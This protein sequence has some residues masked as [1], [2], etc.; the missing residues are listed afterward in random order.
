MIKRISSRRL[1]AIAFTIFTVRLISVLFGLFSAAV[2]IL[3]S[4]YNFTPVLL[5]TAAS[6]FDIIFS[7]SIAVFSDAPIGLLG[8]FLYVIVSG[9]WVYGQYILVIPL[10]R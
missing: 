7:V 9:V 1:Q 5:L 3:L 6:I 4:R 8:R 2:G 10:I